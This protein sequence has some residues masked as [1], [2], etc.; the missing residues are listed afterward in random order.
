MTTAVI[1]APKLTCIEAYGFMTC[2]SFSLIAPQFE[3][4]YAPTFYQST[5]VYADF[6]NLKTI[7]KETPF[8]QPFI[9]GYCPKILNLQSLE[10]CENII[11]TNAAFDTQYLNAPKFTGTLAHNDSENNFNYLKYCNIT[12]ETAKKSGVEYYNVT[13][14]GGS[15]RVTDAGLRFGYSYNEEQTEEVEEYGF[16]YAAGDVDPYTLY[17]EDVD[18]KSVYKLVA[19]NRIT[20]EDNVTTFNLVFID[21]PQTAYDSQVSA[22]AYVKVDGN[23]YYSDKLCYSFNDV[24]TSVLADE[25]IDENTKDALEICIKTERQDQ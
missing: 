17:V 22:R 19:N 9:Y 20:H 1:N 3:T 7:I 14:V 10:Q 12:K 13:D 11:L 8:F 6:P 4:V 16:V 2:A 5:L 18:N 23:Y 21:I 24:A 25:E 15:I